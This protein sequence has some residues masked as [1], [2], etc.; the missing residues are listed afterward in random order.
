MNNKMAKNTCLSKTESKKQM[1]NKNRDRIMDTESVFMVARWEGAVE[2]MCEGMR[3]S[4]ST[5]WK[6]QNS[7]GDERYSIENGVTKGLI[8]I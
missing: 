4:L 6:L 7:H 2:G 5:N 8:F 3:G 1:A